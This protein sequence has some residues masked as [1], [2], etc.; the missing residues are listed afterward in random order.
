MVERT[1]G[2]WK[3][4]STI[5][6]VKKRERILDEICMDGKGRLKKGNEQK[7]WV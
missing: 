7:K 2:G 6:H 3:K 1:S 5:E 4:C